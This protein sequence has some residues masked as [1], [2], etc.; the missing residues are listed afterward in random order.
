MIENMLGDARPRRRAAHTIIS[1]SEGNPLF[2]EQLLSML[3]DDGLIELVDGRWQ[4]PRRP[5]WSHHPPTIHRLLGAVS[6][7]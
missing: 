5:R 6:I 2:V 1:A 7:A 4:T 3:I